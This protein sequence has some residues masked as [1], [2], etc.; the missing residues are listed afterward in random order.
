PGCWKAALTARSVISLNMIRYVLVLGIPSSWARCQPMASPSRSGSVAMN[1]ESD[2]SAAFLRSSS[3]FFLA[4]EAREAG[5][6]LFV[7]STPSLLVGR[8]RTWPMEAF[9]MYFE[10][11]YFWMVLTLVGDSTMT[12]DFFATRVPFIRDAR[13]RSA[14][15]RADGSDPRLPARREGRRRARG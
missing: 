4:G 14:C 13:E 5:V 7:S 1:S 9:T 12:S 2:F 8:S 11:R 15:P 3:T 10:S 6:K